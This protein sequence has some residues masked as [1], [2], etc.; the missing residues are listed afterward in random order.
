LRKEKADINNIKAANVV[1][2][3][4]QKR[5]DF[6]SAKLKDVTN[7]LLREVMKT[8]NNTKHIE[9][10]IQ[11]YDSETQGDEVNNWVDVEGEGYGWLWMNKPERKWHGLIKRNL[12]SFIN[13]KKKEIKDHKCIVLHITTKDLII[14][15]FIEREE[16]QQDTVYTF[17]DK[18]IE[19]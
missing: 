2:T 14:Y 17:S 15:H 4:Y 6:I 19:F 13:D 8:C 10:Q 12:K 11:F 5:D 16:Y 3:E 18:D 1:A 9:E 7:K